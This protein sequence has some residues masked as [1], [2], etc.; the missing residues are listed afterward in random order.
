MGPAKRTSSTGDA[1][2]AG[3]AVMVHGLKGAAQHNGKQ[4]VV[5]RFDGDKDRFIV[6]LEGEK[7]LAIKPENLRRAGL[8]DR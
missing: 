7:E 3:D 2:L 5:Q 1:L 4:G 6:M 8:A